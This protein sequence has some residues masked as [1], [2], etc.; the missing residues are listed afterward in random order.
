[1]EYALRAGPN[2]TSWLAASERRRGVCPEPKSTPG[3][4][5][6]PGELIQT[7]THSVC[8]RLAP[9][10]RLLEDL[11]EAR[12]FA[13]ACN[14]VCGRGSM[15]ANGRPMTCEYKGMQLAPFCPRSTCG[16]QEVTITL[17]DV[18]YYAPSSLS[19]TLISMGQ[20]Y[21]TGRNWITSVVRDINE[22]STSH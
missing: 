4:A 22:T 8:T 12:T 9:D 3:P 6:P 7:V 14:Y 10:I 16:V 13:S 21:D 17:R 5:R 11:L 15:D 18:R 20:L 1:M 2:P 19:D